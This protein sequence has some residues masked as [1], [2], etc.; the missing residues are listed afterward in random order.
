MITAG[1]HDHLRPLWG[2]GNRSDLSIY[3]KDDDGRVIGGLIGRIA[4]RW[5][6]VQRFWVDSAHRGQGLGASVLDAAEAHAISCGCVGSHLDTFGE[7]ALPFYRGR[8]YEV[9]GTLE[10][11]PLG[12]RQHYL[13][14]MLPS[15]PTA[16]PSPNE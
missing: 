9:W 15:S 3:L 12:G 8:G 11:F 2:D 6:Y 14:K 16:S 10:G 5:L 1:L 13:R 7:E 4:W